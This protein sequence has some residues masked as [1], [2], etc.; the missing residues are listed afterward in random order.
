MAKAYVQSV[1]FLSRKVRHKCDE[2]RKAILHV[3]RNVLMIKFSSVKYNDFVEILNDFLRM[4][5]EQ[6][7]PRSAPERGGNGII[8]SSLFGEIMHRKQADKNGKVRYSD[9]YPTRAER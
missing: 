1:A 3:C 8:R 2:M 4:K 6:D 7:F 9:A 5:V